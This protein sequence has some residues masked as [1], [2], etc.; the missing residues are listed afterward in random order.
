MICKIVIIMDQMPIT[1]RILILVH[2]LLAEPSDLTVRQS[3]PSL[4]VTHGQRARLGCFFSFESNSKGAVSWH[5]ADLDG[6]TS[7]SRAVPL[8]H[9]FSLARPKTFLSDGDA[10]LVIGNITGEDAGVYFCK[11]HLWDKAEEQGPGTSLMVHARP[12]HP[13]IYLKVAT[14]SQEDV[15]L[16]C[17]TAGY[18]PPGIAVSWHSNDGDCPDPGPL[19]LWKS[20]SGDYQATRHIVLPSSC[21]TNLLTVSCIVRHISLEA[22]LYAN[23]SHKLSELVVT[24]YH[25]IEYLNIL[26][27]ALILGLTI[28][29]LLTVLKRCKIRRE[30]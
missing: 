26:K 10:S 27:M 28:S 20:E 24:E 2:W 11:V 3:P 23:Y 22:P 18:Y 16:T 14:E 12:S 4:V 19:E 5:K 25:L 9:R 13:E 30:K 6:N 17:H 8:R 15:M 29:I 7:S 1:I 21:R